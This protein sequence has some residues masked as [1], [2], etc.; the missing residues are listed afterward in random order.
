MRAP[1]LGRK[2]EA[3][4]VVWCNRD[5]NKRKVQFNTTP[6]VHGRSVTEN[7][8]AHVALPFFPCNALVV[9]HSR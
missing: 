4:T 5:Q 9:S 8:R 1:L 6:C 7:P 2:V 3:R